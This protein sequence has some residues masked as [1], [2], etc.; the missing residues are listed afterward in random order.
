MAEGIGISG[1]HATLNKIPSP[2]IEARLREELKKK[3]IK[4]AGAV[5][6]DP[7]ISHA[8]FAGNKLPDHTN[9]EAQAK[10]VATAILSGQD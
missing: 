3:Q 9:A 5:Y 6:L 1:I 7:Q 2:E 4:V 8:G 10:K